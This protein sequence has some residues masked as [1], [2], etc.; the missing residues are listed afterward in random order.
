MK[1][2]KILLIVSI[3][4]WHRY[5]MGNMTFIPLSK[6]WTTIRA[7]SLVIWN[8]SKGTWRARE[9]RANPRFVSHIIKVLSSAPNK[10][11][12]LNLK[13]QLAFKISMSNH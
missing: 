4:L 12:I 7:Q 2:L 9:V 3:L 5:K 11:G 13:P 8:P 10:K 1:P 6:R